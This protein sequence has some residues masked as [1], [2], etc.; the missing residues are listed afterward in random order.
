MTT[1]DK[2]SNAV[3]TRF[4]EMSKNELYVVDV[5]GDELYE[6]YLASFPDGTNPIYKERTEHDCSC[7]KNFI[8]N[9][10]NVVAIKNC[11]PV[12]VE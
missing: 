8:R 3:H 9:I 5:S 7:C 4:N 12:T 10:G 1:F 6:L 2:F 11:N